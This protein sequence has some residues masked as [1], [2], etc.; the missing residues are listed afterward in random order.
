MKQT[1][2]ALERLF[3]KIL[4]PFERF[5]RRATAGGVILM[6][7]TVLTLVLANS[8]WGT[9]LHHLWEQKAHITIGNWQLELTLH[10]WV[11]EG[12]MSLFFLLVGLELKREI[13]V[14]ELSSIGIATLPVVA[15][16]GGMVVPALVYTLI[17]PQ[18]P[19]V[20][21]WGIPMATDIA[22][23]IGILVLLSWRIPKSL[24][25]FLTALAIADDLGAVL[26]IALFYTKEFSL[27]ALAIGAAVLTLLVILNQGGI[28]HPLPY[29]ILGLLLWL[30]LLNS[31]V[32]ATHI[33][34][35]TGLHHSGLSGL[36]PFRIQRTFGP[37]RTKTSV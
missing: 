4:T 33:R 24:I 2:Y 13:L 16:V 36:F 20:K 15:A 35:F 17:V 19:M 3:G 5:L 30:S 23:S 11:N 27:Q 25:L 26:V 21:G 28:R 10:Q 12:L 32:H 29:G 6:G 31:G 34:Y 8:I 9:D 37:V 14:G 18:G 22:F 7:T 1:N